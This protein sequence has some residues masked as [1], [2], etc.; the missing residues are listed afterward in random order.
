[1]EKSDEFYLINVV[2]AGPVS[3]V[4]ANEVLS[5]NEDDAPGQRARVEEAQ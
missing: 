3:Y 4:F 5:S 1:M 2:V